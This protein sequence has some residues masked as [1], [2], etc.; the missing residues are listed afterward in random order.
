MNRLDGVNAISG[1]EGRA[2]AKIDGNNEEMFFARRIEAGVEKTKAT[3]KALGKRMAGHK[4]IGG[5]GKGTMSLYYLSPLFRGLLTRWRSTGQ[6]VFFDLVIE[7]DDIQSAAGTQ[8]VLLTG[9]NLDGGV[10]ALLDG[11]ADNPLEEEVSFT[12]EDFT[13]MTP[14]TKF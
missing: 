13:V 9:V 2:Y 7:N 11:T 8:Q 10:L 4:T 5:E 3:V 12:F 1:R 6:D 14:F